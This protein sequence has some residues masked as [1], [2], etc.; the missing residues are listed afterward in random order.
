MQAARDQ[1]EPDEDVM[2]QPE[3]GSIPAFPT[4]Y[5]RY[6]DGIYDF[7]VRTVG[8]PDTAAE[9]VQKTFTKAQESMQKGRSGPNVEAW[10]YTIARKGA[11]DEMRH[12][13]RLGSSDEA[14]EGGGGPPVLAQP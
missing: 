8:R 9:V 6:F 10:L 7:A 5:E 4:L 12:G 13:E 14:T 11:I 3:L 2:A 1:E